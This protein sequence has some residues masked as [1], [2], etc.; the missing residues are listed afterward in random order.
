MFPDRESLRRSL[1]DSVIQWEP[2]INEKSRSGYIRGPFS[3][4]NLST[5]WIHYVITDMEK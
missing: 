4:M 2:L 5:E 1:T 3:K